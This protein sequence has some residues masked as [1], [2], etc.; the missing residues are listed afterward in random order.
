M[1]L[2]N[3]YIYKTIIVIKSIMENTYKRTSYDFHIMHPPEFSLENKNK[4]KKIRKNIIDVRL[5]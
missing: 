4:L 1:S 3:I 2:D 5:I